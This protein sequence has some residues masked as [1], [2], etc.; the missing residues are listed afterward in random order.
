MKDIVID[1]RRVGVAGHLRLVDRQLGSLGDDARE[2]GRELQVGQWVALG[3]PVGWLARAWRWLVG[4]TTDKL[5]GFGRVIGTRYG[6]VSFD[7]VTWRTPMHY[8]GTLHVYL[9]EMVEA[10]EGARRL[11]ELLS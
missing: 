11:Q 1:G 6:C 7:R 8:E 10:R 4:G 2:L 5:I 3:R 9:S